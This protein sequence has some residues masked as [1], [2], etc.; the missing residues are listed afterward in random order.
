MEI[1]GHV[2]SV[3]RIINM[4]RGVKKVDEKKKLF[5]MFLIF[6]EGEV[7]DYS[8]KE[9]WQEFL[10]PKKKKNWQESLGPKK[11]KTDKNPLDLRRKKNWQESLGPKKKKL[12]KK[13]NF[14]VRSN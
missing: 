11:K 3:S 10:G 2:V 9:N 6:G 13:D 14:L 8:N 12:S 1:T 5:L 4:K 7:L